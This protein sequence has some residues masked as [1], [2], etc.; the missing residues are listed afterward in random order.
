MPPAGTTSKSSGC[1]T[2]LVTEYSETRCCNSDAGAMFAGT[3][4]SL[5]WGTVPAMPATP[6]E[7]QGS[8]GLRPI[9]VF[10]TFQENDNE[11]MSD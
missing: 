2:G 9:I 8:K 4:P 3:A 7:G 1:G 11:S 6:D 5:G 10:H